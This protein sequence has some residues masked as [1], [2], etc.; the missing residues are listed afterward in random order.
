MAPVEW[1]NTLRLVGYDFSPS[2][3]KPGNPVNLVLTWQLL[4]YTGINKKIFLQ[5]FDQSGNPIGQTEQLRNNRSIAGM[6]DVSTGQRLPV[7]GSVDGTVAL[8]MSSAV[9]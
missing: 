4:N 2:Q 9:E 5:I 7:E 6:Y 1:S 8:E 3:V